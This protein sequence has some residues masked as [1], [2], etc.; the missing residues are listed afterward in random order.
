MK[1][2]ILLL[3]CLMLLTACAPAETEAPSETQP[4]PLIT[5]TIYSGNDNADG[6]VT[7][8]IQVEEISANTLV[9]R[10][11]QAGILTE[12]IEILAFEAK[13]A[14]LNLDFSSGF[15]DLIC[16]QG[17][18]GEYI[19]M[20]SVVN[21]FLDAYAAETVSITVDNQILESGHVIYDFPMARFE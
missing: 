21:T 20:G 11:I 16:S 5:I 19:L 10:L 3:L 15:R 1:Q 14:Q 7:S 18:A 17:T 6:F 13:G 2:I 12:D 9:E 4:A 8:Q